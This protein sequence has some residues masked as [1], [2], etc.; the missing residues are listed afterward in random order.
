M[1]IPDPD[2]FPFRIPDPWVKK[3]PDPGSG[4]A[5]LSVFIEPFHVTLSDQKSMTIM[6]QLFVLARITIS[7]KFLLL[8][9][10]A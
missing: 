9:M 3:A 10:C 4:S 6:L 7:V 2:L 1:F 8:Y 5:T